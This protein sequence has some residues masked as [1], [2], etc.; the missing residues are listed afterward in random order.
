MPRNTDTRD[1]YEANLALD[2]ASGWL[3]PPPPP[4]PPFAAGAPPCCAC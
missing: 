3:P 2:A 1:A 4:P